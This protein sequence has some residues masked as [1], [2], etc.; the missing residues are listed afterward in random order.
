[1]LGEIGGELKYGVTSGLTLDLTYNTDFAQVEV[2]DQQINLDRF[3]LFFP[4]KRP[5]FLEN[6]GAFTVSNRGGGFNDTSQTELF[7]SRRIGIGAEGQPIPI[8]GGARLSG[9]VSNS[10]T[11]G[12]LNMQTESMG[13][14]AANNFTV[15]RV[16][17]DLANRSSIG[18]LFVNRQAT[19]RRPCDGGRRSLVGARPDRDDAGRSSSL[20]KPGSDRHRPASQSRLLSES[21]RGYRRR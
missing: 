4:E 3:S 14:T 11:V 7:F 16:R 13:Q 18:G 2:D 21:G 9:K 17:Q 6:A 20:T 19:G 15:A 5:F 10:V 1:M 8:L 12:V